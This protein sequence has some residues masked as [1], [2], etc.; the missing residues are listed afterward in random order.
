MIK[1]NNYEKKIIVAE[2]YRN[3]GEFEEAIETLALIK[4][5]D[6]YKNHIKAIKEAAE[7]GDTE[8]VEIKMN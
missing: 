7:K 2:L 8:I 4:D 3:I 6:E 1:P 5:I